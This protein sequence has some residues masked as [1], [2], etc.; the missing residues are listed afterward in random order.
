MGRC[1]DEYSGVDPE[2]E[3]GYAGL[4]GFVVRIAIRFCEAVLM[5]SGVLLDCIPLATLKEFLRLTSV[6]TTLPMQSCSWL[7][8]RQRR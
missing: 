3:L 2:G 7:R 4:Y 6:R 8:T 1:C 5:M